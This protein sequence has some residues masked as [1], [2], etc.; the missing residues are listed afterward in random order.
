MSAVINL[1][2]HILR[3]SSIWSKMFVRG[4]KKQSDI[5]HLSFVWSWFCPSSG[6]I[7]RRLPFLK[8]F[9]AETIRESTDEGHVLM[10]QTWEDPDPHAVGVGLRLGNV[11]INNIS[12]FLGNAT[13]YDIYLDRHI[14]SKITLNI[15]RGLYLAHLQRTETSP[16]FWSRLI[17]ETGLYF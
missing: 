3:F 9:S 15:G 10:T 7:R 11:L 17:L 1:H 12:I 14:F 6:L 5:L 2:V 4:R 8:T 16:S 13:I